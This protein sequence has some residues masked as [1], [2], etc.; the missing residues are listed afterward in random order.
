M[1]NEIF[2][3]NTEKGG[4]EALWLVGLGQIRVSGVSLLGPWCPN[5]PSENGIGSCSVGS[6]VPGWH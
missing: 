2:E 5:L 6:A 3:G 1:V 4:L